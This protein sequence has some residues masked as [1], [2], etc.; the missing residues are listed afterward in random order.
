MGKNPRSP[1]CQR[2]ISIEPPQPTTTETSLQLMQ[3]LTEAPAIG[4]DAS[5]GVVT[6]VKLVQ[7]RQAVERATVHFCQAVVLQVPVEKNQKEL[8]DKQLWSNTEG[9]STGTGILAIPSTYPP[10]YV[11]VRAFFVQGKDKDSR[12]TQRKCPEQ[13]LTAEVMLHCK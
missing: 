11:H 7:R 13:A 3:L 1:F 9:L 12:T 10:G 8:T 4:V 5:D 2:Y 6:E